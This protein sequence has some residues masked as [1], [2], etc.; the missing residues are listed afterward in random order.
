MR[1]FLSDIKALVSRA[2]R[3]ICKFL[4]SVI[5]YLFAHPTTEWVILTLILYFITDSL[6]RRSF[7]QSV[8]FIFTSPVMF[9][10][11]FSIVAIGTSFALIFRHRYFFY[12]LNLV[13]WLTLSITDFVL[14]GMRAD[15]FS[16]VDLNVIVTA[17]GIV[18]KYIGWGGIIAIIAAFAASASLLVLLWRRHPKIVRL[19]RSSAALR[20][21]TLAL[22]ICV[23]SIS[24]SYYHYIPDNFENAAVAYDTYGFPYCFFRSFVQRGVSTPDEYSED[25]IDALTKKLGDTENTAKDVPNVI[26][27]QLESFFD[28][29]R[30]KGLSLSENPIPNFTSL[31]ESCASGKL[32]VNTI[33]GGT[34]NTEFEVLCGMNLTHFGLLECPYTT[35]LNRTP[36]RSA[37][38]VFA[39]CGLT[40]HAIHNHIATFYDRYVVYPNLGF[41]TFTPVE[42]MKNIERNSL[43]WVKDSCLEGEIM[44]ALSSTE[45]NDFI[46]T[47]SVQPHGKYPDFETAGDDDIHVL[48]YPDEKM[49]FDIEYY[50]NEINETDAFLGSVIDALRDYP[51]DV[52]V[53]A[54]GDHL[55]ILGLDDESMFSGDL[56]S[57]EYV[58]WTNFDSDYEG[59][60]IQA[61]QLAAKVMSGL[62]IDGGGMFSIHQKLSDDPDYDA[63]M[64]LMEYDSLEGEHFA[65]HGKAPVATAMSFGTEEIRVTG[66]KQYGDIL[67][68]A[69]ENF[70]ESSYVFVNDR[71]LDTTLVNDSLLVVKKAKLHEGDEIYTAQLCE[72]G[73]LLSHSAPFTYSSSDE[74]DVVIPDDIFS[75]SKA[76]SGRY[77]DESETYDTDGAPLTQN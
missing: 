18:P 37:A 77:G 10:F 8:V 56:Y 50:V 62:G 2:G 72:G 27:L 44:S 45:E 12:L 51:E 54:Y 53:V 60:D 71:R 25:A 64:K 3:G 69:G 4:S 14:L 73:T 9:L 1:K 57:T 20:T 24:T 28:V 7:I 11:N 76:D 16:A 67:F 41:D 42:Y 59:G 21:A 30:V 22:I 40:T 32:R 55:P 39:E 5:R 29:N 33:G 38:S 31:K 52:V 6:C 36:C 66:A 63:Y 49:I 19:N 15:P 75:G 70:T 35:I 48:S 47:V 61:F 13:F 68:V 23:L 74:G 43:G 58:I 65:T 46:F 26:L 17:L 34:A